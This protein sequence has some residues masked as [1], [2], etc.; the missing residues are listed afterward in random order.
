MVLLALSSITVPTSA[1]QLKGPVDVLPCLSRARYERVAALHGHSGGM[2]PLRALPPLS[3]RACFGVNVVI[4]EKNTG[5]V[6]DEGKLYLDRNANGSLLDDPPVALDAGAQTLTLLAPY[7]VQLTASLMDTGGNRALRVESHAVRTGRIDVGSGPVAF[8]I[9]GTSASF[10]H[11]SLAF[12][13]NGDGEFDTSDPQSLELFSQSDDAVNLAGKSYG[14]EV[15]PDG[16]S[17]TLT[18]LPEKRPER[19]Q[20]EPGTRIPTITVRDVADRPVTLGIG[21]P[22]VLLYFWSSNCGGWSIEAPKIA[23]LDAIRNRGYELVGINTDDD[24]ESYKAS[25]LAHGLGSRQVRETRRGTLNRL[26]RVD[27]IPRYIVLDGDGIIRTVRLES[28]NYHEE[29][30]AALGAAPAV[31]PSNPPE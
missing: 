4:G 29:I 3:D 16:T 7:P 21:G 12:D 23:A 2:V 6:V 20:I 31:T 25:L 30:R 24:L 17:L 5:W 18:P 26:F 1:A 13:L 19:L 14:I 8:L 10:A 11:P 28:G 27:A 22:P 9:L 15:A